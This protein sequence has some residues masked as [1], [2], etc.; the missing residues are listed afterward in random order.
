MN[1]PNY[2]A[3]PPSRSGRSV[4]EVSEEAA[5][6]AGDVIRNRFLTDKEV[7]FKGRADIV[8]DVGP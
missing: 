6:R 1:Q 2:E 3:I 5:R 4:L 8:T 7:R